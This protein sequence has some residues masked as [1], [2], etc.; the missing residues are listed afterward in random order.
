MGFR[1]GYNNGRYNALCVLVYRSGFCRISNIPVNGCDDQIIYLVNGE[2]LSGEDM[3]E[4]PTRENFTAIGWEDIDLS[5]VEED[6]IVNGIYNGISDVT[7]EDGV[8]TVMVENAEES[9]LVVAVYS[10]EAGCLI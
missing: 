9:I 2:S 10:M 8:A 1:Y 7:L 3:P 5:N 4:L 6:L